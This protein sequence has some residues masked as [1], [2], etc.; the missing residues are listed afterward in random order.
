MGK[1]FVSCT[2]HFSRL[3]AIVLCGPILMAYFQFIRYV[4]IIHYV[5]H[6]DT[7]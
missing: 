7:E 3:H 6:V 5:K 1:M 2:S 4:M